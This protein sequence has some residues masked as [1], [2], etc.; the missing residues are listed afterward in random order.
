MIIRAEKYNL[1]RNNLLI[2]ILLII[3]ITGIS[4]VIFASPDNSSAESQLPDPYEIQSLYSEKY[5][6][7]IKNHSKLKIQIAGATIKIMQ[8]ATLPSPY[9]TGDIAD[10]C[11]TGHIKLSMS[12]LSGPSPLGVRIMNATAHNAGRQYWPNACA[13]A[14]ND[15]LKS[16]G[17]DITSEVNYNP[18]WVP[19]YA[20]LG[21]KIEKRGDLKPGDLVIYDNEVNEGPYDHIGIYAGNGMAYN[22]STA[23]GYKFVLT[24]I[25]VSFQEGRRI[26]VADY[27]GEAVTVYDFEDEFSYI[28]SKILL[29]ESKLRLNLAKAYIEYM[30]CNFSYYSATLYNLTL[31]QTY[32]ENELEKTDLPEEKKTIEEEINYLQMLKGLAGENFVKDKNNLSV[33]VSLI[34]KQLD[35][36]EKSFKIAE[37]NMDKNAP[38]LIETEKELNDLENEYKKLKKSFSISVNE[39]E[40][41]ESL[42]SFPPKYICSIDFEWNTNSDSSVLSETKRDLKSSLTLYTEGLTTYEKIEEYKDSYR[43]AVIESRVDG[44]YGNQEKLEEDA[45]RP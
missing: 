20:N 38:L 6:I 42:P 34:K 30:N 29:L 5:D 19:N 2:I 12:D 25:G 13:H 40:E 7:Y 15:V 4:P 22:V 44:F 16:L 21:Q 33:Y 26:G 27:E 28:K 17:I 32:L 3:F 11:W 8:L 14:V 41:E 9:K 39:T 1:Y 18:D 37:E 36:A 24:P 45:Y 31:H 10:S 43:E 35:T 23:K